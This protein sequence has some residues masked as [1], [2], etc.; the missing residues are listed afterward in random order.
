MYKCRHDSMTK[1]KMH[2]SLFFC[3]QFDEYKLVLKKLIQRFFLKPTQ[4]ILGHIML[5]SLLLLLNNRLM[6]NLISIDL[7]PF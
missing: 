2:D 4:Y 1:K 7:Y 5:N 3:F 6:I